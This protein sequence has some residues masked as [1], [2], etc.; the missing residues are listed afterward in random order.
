MTPLEAAHLAHQ[1]YTDKP[2]FGNAGDSGR[3]VMYGTAIGFP[4]TDNIA[5]WLADLDVETI[6]VPGLGTVHA[7]FWR[8]WKEIDAGILGQSNIDVLLG[9][10][11]GAALALLCAACL[12]LIDRA[13]KTVF[14][15]EPPRIS[16]DAT[17][18]LLL[19]DHW[20]DVYLYRNGEDVVPLVP[21]L[22]ENWQHPGPLIPIGKALH[23]FPNVDDHYMVNV[24]QA[25]TELAPPAVGS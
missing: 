17:I 6:P 10:S 13:P 15:F 2:T 12:C 16:I 11:E 22:V 23:P 20:V 4:G 24:I 5:T 25:I 3:G 18:G 21:R 9:H 8:S 1:C 7:G 14:A 19:I